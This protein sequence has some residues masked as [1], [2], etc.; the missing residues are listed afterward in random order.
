MDSPDIEE[1]NHHLTNLEQD[2]KSLLQAYSLEKDKLE[3]QKQG[4]SEQINQS[5]S[6]LNQLKKTCK[7]ISISC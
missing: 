6:K 1:V 4:L 7:N 5:K 2:V 3:N